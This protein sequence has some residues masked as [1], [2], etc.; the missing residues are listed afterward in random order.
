[1][2][3]NP[4]APAGGAAPLDPYV[5]SL[6][7]GFL[8]SGSVTATTPWVAFPGEYVA[9]CESSGDASWLQVTHAPGTDRRP[10]LTALQDATPG[11][12]IPSST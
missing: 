11:L 12:A 3:V 5:P 1:M 8:G 6:V 7:L 9:R 10:S 2:C 4:A